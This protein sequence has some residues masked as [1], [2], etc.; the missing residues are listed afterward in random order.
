MVDEDYNAK[1]CTKCGGKPKPLIEFS[2]HARSRD[3]LQSNCKACN[4]IASTAYRVANSDKEKKRCA[5]YRA[6]NT[7][8]ARAYRA[9]NADRA[10]ARASAWYADNPDRAR[11]S[12]AKW[13][14]KNRETVKAATADWAAAHPE[15]VRIHHHN[16]RARRRAVGGRLS[17]GLTEKLFKL[18][19][20]KCACGCKQP[21]GDD[22]HRD[23]RMPIALGGANE[24]W[25]IQ[26][27][28]AKCNQQKHKTHPVDFMRERGF[29]I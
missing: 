6:A 23:H 27:L 28:R 4:S 22:F 25:N 21:L 7:D 29:L 5:A 24:D 12:R 8:K 9:A 19:R 1:Q 20:G 17:I 14:T 16:T 10:M 15:A 13:Y 26:L 3:G 11:T 18:Q 2:K